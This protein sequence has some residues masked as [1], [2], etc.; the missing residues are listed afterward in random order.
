M[1]FVGVENSLKREISACFEVEHGV[2]ISWIKSLC[3]IRNLCAHHSRVWNRVL[4]IKPK[5]PN[6]KKVESWKDVKNN[7]IFCVILIIAG[8]LK[9]IGLSDD[10]TERAQNLFN[11]NRELLSSMGFPENWGRYFR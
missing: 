10:W 4:A 7:K 3:Y 2:L 8:M 9:S 6:K 1:F 5:I 11:G